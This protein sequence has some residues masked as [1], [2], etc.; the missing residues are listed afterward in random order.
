MQKQDMTQVPHE[1]VYD[2]AANV[3]ADAEEEQK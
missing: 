1:N 3:E 2:S